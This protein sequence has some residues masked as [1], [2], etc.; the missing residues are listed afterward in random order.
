MFVCALLAVPPYW[1]P[2]G[3]RIHYITKGCDDSADCQRK[4][5]NN[6]THCKRDWWNDWTCYD[7]C[8]GPKCNYY[9]TVS[10]PEVVMCVSSVV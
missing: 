4:K 9:V 2:G 8:S 6:K 7:C 10:I 1:T 5:D 3:V